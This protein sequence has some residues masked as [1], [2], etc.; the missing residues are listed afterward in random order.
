MVRQSSWREGI[1]I[2]FVIHLFILLLLPKAFFRPEVAQKAPRHFQV[3]RIDQ[4]GLAKYRGVG[5]KNGSKY[6]SLPL[7]KKEHS[8]PFSLESLKVE[9]PRQIFP[10]RETA[11]KALPDKKDILRRF[12]TDLQSR[13]LMNR[14]NLSIR[15]LPPEGVDEDELNSVEKIFWSFKKR[16]YLSYISSFIKTYNQFVL[17]RPQ[18]KQAIAREGHTIEGRV[19]FDKNG[20]IVRIKITRPSSNDDFHQLFEETLKGIHK[21][22]NPP[23]NILEAEQFTVYYQLRINT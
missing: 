5:I 22:P 2:S 13:K 15:F 10:S 12:G 14:S 8:A 18:I 16:T 4:E 3:E 20:N 7:P 21:L 23:K 1:L 11:L 6:F 19:I 17:R 9:K